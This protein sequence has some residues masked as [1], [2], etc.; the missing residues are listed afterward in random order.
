MLHV[1]NYALHIKHYPQD[2]CGIIE[3][4]IILLE[5]AEQEA[6][7]FSSNLRLLAKK[8]IK[9]KFIRVINCLYELS[10]FTDK[11]GGNITKKEVFEIVGKTVNQDLSS[12]QNDMSTTKAAANSDMYNTLEIFKLMHAKQQEINNK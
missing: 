7:S 9:V 2:V 5:K 10:F 1:L 4:K 8:G 3:K 11:Q 12:F 6:A